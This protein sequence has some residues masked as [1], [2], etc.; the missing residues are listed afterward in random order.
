MFLLVEVKPDRDAVDAAFGQVFRY[1]HQFLRD[2]TLPGSTLAM[3]AS[4]LRPPSSTN[5]IG[6]LRQRAESDS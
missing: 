4:R 2:R 5:R 6:W 1:R 3:S